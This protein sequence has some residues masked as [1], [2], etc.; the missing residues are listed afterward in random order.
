MACPTRLL[1]CLPTLLADTNSIYWPW[2]CEQT[3]LGARIMKSLLQGA[4]ALRSCTSSP[5]AFQHRRH[6]CLAA[7]AAAAATAA[8]A[9][10]SS[11]WPSPHAVPQP[12]PRAGI[13]PPIISMSWDTFVLPMVFWAAAASERRHAALS[14]LDRRIVVLFFLFDLFNTVRGE[15]WNPW[16]VRRRL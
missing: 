8:A 10:A 2:Y 15:A 11:V 7:A 3:S 5:G 4:H 9:A 6:R 14:D 12:P 1:L 16:T 13:L